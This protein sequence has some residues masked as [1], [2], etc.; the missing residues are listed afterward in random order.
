MTFYEKCLLY[1]RHMFVAWNIMVSNKEY[2]MFI[3][4]KVRFV[5]INRNPVWIFTFSTEHRLL[6]NTAFIPIWSVRL[7]WT[8]LLSLF[9]RILW[10]TCFSPSITW[11]KPELA[12]LLLKN[13]FPR[14]YLV[15]NVNIFL[16]Q[17][18]FSRASW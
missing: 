2:N 6:Y 15:K 4:K 7:V 13:V 16:N 14:W 9:I 12:T 5:A 11:E 10:Q 8:W 17:I 18:T 1:T 3:H